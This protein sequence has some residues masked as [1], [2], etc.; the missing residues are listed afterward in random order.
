MF[1]CFLWLHCSV[2]NDVGYKSI[3]VYQGILISKVFC[4]KVGSEALF[5]DAHIWRCA[6]WRHKIKRGMPLIDFSSLLATEGCLFNKQ[7][8]GWL[9]SIDKGD[10]SRF[11]PFLLYCVRNRETCDHTRCPDQKLLSKL[12]VN[13]LSVQSPFNIV[14]IYK[15]FAC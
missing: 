4:I 2:Y 15:L 14:N 7:S 5:N 9:L 3:V 11:I 6:I 12:I 8:V 13:T 1:L 10:T